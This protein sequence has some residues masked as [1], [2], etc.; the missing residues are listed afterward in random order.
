MRSPVSDPMAQASA[1]VLGC[2]DTAARSSTDAEEGAVA[3]VMVL[4]LCGKNDVQS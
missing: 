4:D 1:G 3:M 2:G